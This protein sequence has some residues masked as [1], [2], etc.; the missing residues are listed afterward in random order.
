MADL[1]GLINKLSEQEQ[2][3]D[4]ILSGLSAQPVNNA[5]DSPVDDDIL[6]GLIAPKEESVDDDILSG[7]SSVGETNEFIAGS[8]GEGD[9][10]P[11]QIQESAERGFGEMITSDRGKV[12]K[13]LG[14]LGAPQDYAT[15]WLVYGL[16]QLGNVSDEEAKSLLSRDQ[17]APSDIIRYYWKPESTGGKVARTGVGLLTDIVSDPLN[18]INPVG[19]SNKAKNLMIAGKSINNVQNLQRTERAFLNSIKKVEK[20]IDE[21]GELKNISGLPDKKNVEVIADFA[22]RKIGFDDFIEGVNVS[23]GTKGQIRSVM[24]EANPTLFQEMQAGERAVTVGMQV[25]FTNLA[26]EFEVPF[27]RQAYKALGSGVRG[28][29]ESMYD[30]GAWAYKTI[31]DD[32]LIREATDGLVA[33]ADRMTNVLGSFAT[34]TGFSM[35]DQA[36]GKYAGG[37]AFDDYVSTKKY[38]QWTKELQKILPDDPKESEEV[39]ADILYFMEREMSPADMNRALKDKFG[40]G[41]YMPKQTIKGPKGGFL[42]ELKINQNIKELLPTAADLRR[43]AKLEKYPGLMDVIEDIRRTNRQM[44]E[45]YKSR[46]IPMDELNPFGE[47]WARN[48]VKHIVSDKYLA[49][50]KEVDEAGR[51]IDQELGRLTGMVDPSS[52][53]RKYRGTVE[54]ANLKSLEEKGVKIFVDDPIELAHLRQKEMQKVIRDYDLFQEAST[55]AIKG[56]KPPALGYQ[57][58]RLKDFEKY[59][60]ENA[61]FK[62]ELE[63]LDEAAQ[64][65]LIRGKIYDIFLPN[66]YKTDQNIY[67]PSQIYDRL[68]QSTRGSN[69]VN[70]I[71]RDATNLAMG[72]YNLFNKVFKASALFGTGYLGM[73]AMGNAVQSTIHGVRPM[74]VADATSLFIPKWWSKKERRLKPFVKGPEDFQGAIKLSSD[75]PVKELT[76]EELWE[77]ALE[78]N[79]LRSGLTE[80][81]FRFGDYV[82]NMATTNKMRSKTPGLD[83]IESMVDVAYL[84]QPMRAAAQ[85]SDDI[86]KLA[87]FIDRLRDGF[88]YEAAAE[89]VD[90]AFYSY[91]I[92]GT[93]QKIAA[94]AIPFSTFPMKTAEWIADSLRDGR[95]SR[96]TMPEKAR[97]VLQAEYVDS[98]EDLAARK[99]MMAPELAL[100]QDPVHGAILPG[101]KEVLF[102]LPWAVSTMGFLFDPTENIHP[103]FQLLFGAAASREEMEEVGTINKMETKKSISKV[104]DMVVPSY[105]REALAVAEINGL[106]NLDGYFAGKYR[107]EIPVENNLM[108]PS[109]QPGD[110]LMFNNDVEFGKYMESQMGENWLYRLMFPKGID[111]YGENDIERQELAARGEFIRRRFRDLTGGVARLNRMDSNFL[112]NRGAMMRQHTKVKKKLEVE[113]NK[114]G[115]MVDAGALDDE[116]Y[117]G[118]LSK[119]YPEARD[120]I[121]LN[122]KIEALNV[123]YDFY[124]RVKYEYPEFDWSLI[125]GFKSASENMSEIADLETRQE[126]LMAIDRDRSARQLSEEELKRAMIL[127]SIKDEGEENESEQPTD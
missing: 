66:F 70:G 91:N 79:I 55:Y 90:R 32:G 10:T 17:V 40:S 120:M 37:R 92:G 31:P 67:I 57:K 64:E 60:Q 77:K 34:R 1:S 15:R 11:G 119:R 41:V 52:A 112:L 28:A 72:A 47:N 39:M 50:I 43:F 74:A 81:T 95:I 42:T 26:F 127:N 101:S 117:L 84:W 71:P 114:L 97:R 75:G 80:E 103:L 29:T 86:P 53:G 20:V 96:L 6:S 88:S 13:A 7:L 62:G 56:E 3:D 58:F 93:G 8:F 126:L 9:L 87:M 63:G 98:D 102:E 85:F 22:D 5:A 89:A 14:I 4:D 19:L 116:G 122:N 69:R 24:A 44:V 38:S 30:L 48:Y 108:N 54:A 33:T 73:N 123:Y 111:G 113:L 115:A 12:T 21:A 78:Y 51:H 2:V 125:F 100:L 99:N 49:S 83:K 23:P 105:A 68:L 36:L 107:R 106:V 124:N 82:Q 45:A 46:G 35:F 27:T 16:N 76:Q 65:A 61:F 25:P 110:V 18:F 121:T 104:L 109:E 94:Q 118:E 59:F